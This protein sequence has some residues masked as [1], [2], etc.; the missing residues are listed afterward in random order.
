MLSTVAQYLDSATHMATAPHLPL[1]TGVLSWNVAGKPVG[2][3]SVVASCPQEPIGA[4]VLRS[5][6]MRK[7][8]GGGGGGGGGGAVTLGCVLSL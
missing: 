7:T 6:Q 4:V 1:S 2:G 5:D 3:P 8:T